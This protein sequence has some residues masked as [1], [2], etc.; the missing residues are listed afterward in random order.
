MK[1]F[2]PSASLNISTQDTY[3]SVM[4]CNFTSYANFEGIQ[5]DEQH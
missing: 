1:L 3:F 4:G 2:F 5:K